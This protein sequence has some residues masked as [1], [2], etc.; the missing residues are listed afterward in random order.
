[1]NK[2]L[3]TILKLIKKNDSYKSLLSQISTENEV[4]LKNSAGSLI[5]L[6]ILSISEDLAGNTIFISNNISRLD[7]VFHD[8][9]LYG[10]TGNLNLIKEPQA[11]LRS[12]VS[13]TGSML[14]SLI[15]GL[16]SFSRNDSNILICQPEMFYH[17]IPSNQKIEGHY[18][19]I[20]KGDNTDYDSFIKS[21]VL[22]G[23]ERMD[24]ISGQG[25]IAVRGGIIDLYPIGWTNPLRIEFWGNDIDSIREFEVLSQRSIRE[26]DS[27]EF[28][29]SM[30]I[31][32]DSLEDDKTA[33]DY[34]DSDTI[35]FFD[36]NV[37][38]SEILENISG[39]N[40][41]SLILNPVGSSKSGIN[42]VN[43]PSFNG[44]VK[45]L[46]NEINRLSL[47]NFKIFLSCEGK[48]HLD[49]FK[50][51]IKSTVA[52]I[53][54]S[55][56][57]TNF[58]LNDEILDKVVNWDSESLS[59]GFISDELKAAYFTEH[60]VFERHRIYDS[61]RSGKSK[62]LTL[63]ELQELR[64][65]DYV[66]HEDKGIGI[67]DGF[68][69]IKIGD[70]MQDCARVRFADG[71]MLYVHLNYI[72]KLSKYSAQDGAAPILSKL[73]STDW[74]RRKAR[75][76][77]RLKD[78]ARDLIKLYAERKAQKGYAF[79]PDTT[80]Q[81]EFE[82]SFIYEDTPD[83]ATATEDVKSDMESTSPM[84][85][86]ICGDVGFGK[87]E[88]AI[89]AAF[90]AVQSGKQAA[91]LVPTTILAQQHF[92]SFKDRLS[93]YPVNVDV[94]SR[95]RKRKDQ[96]EITEKIKQG[97]I[98]ILI[99]THRILSKDI[100]FKNLGLLVVDE[101]HRFGVGH[102]EKL[103][104]LRANV[105]TLT[106]TA[107]PIP[108]TLNFSLMGARDLSLIETPP[109]NRIPVITEIIEWD[110]DII[111]QAINTEIERGGQV[112][113]V[114]DK[115]EDIQKIATDIKA[116][117]P[118]L[119]IAVGHGQMKPSDLEEI[120]EEF[121]EG[122][123]DI[124]VATKIIESGID[125]P[126]ANTMIINRAQNF[127]LAELYQLRGRVGRSNV[128][129]YC[130]LLAPP[131]HKLQQKSIQRLQAIEEF[132]ELGSGFKLSMRDL[133]IRG[134]GN[135]LGAEQSGFIIDIGFEL[136]QKV[137][138]EAVNELK[139]SEFS[140][141]F[142]ES[143]IDDKPKYLNEEI[144]IETDEDAL[145]PPDYIKGDTDRFMYYKKLYSLKNTSEL[146]DIVNEIED[147]FGKMPK[148][149]KN[150]VFAVR[151]RIAALTTG[152]TRLIIK[153]NKLVCEFPPSDFKEYYDEVFPHIVDYLNQ[154]EGVSL[155]QAKEKVFLE[156]PLRKRDETLE[157]IWKIKKIT[158]LSYT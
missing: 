93:K 45:I 39:K 35:L 3:G 4:H 24:Y 15:E 143:P 151:L 139:V 80:W 36:D 132:T 110:K 122:K 155:R 142:G 21:L 152:F 41:K 101:E 119:N 137:L 88:V 56:D 10:F 108:R 70:S 42:S 63:K 112:F 16:I 72:G 87:T 111:I 149:A 107:T 50:Q 6:L 27:V 126:N 130:Y 67:F 109:R 135:L 48:I 91:V 14:D 66:V 78:I 106:L 104:Q 124:L 156:I 116:Y 47:E 131:A 81:S 38:P 117:L 59:K 29:D 23:F 103:R 123:Y 113:F 157:Y 86:L 84:D 154:T 51:L 74:L 26:F 98:D 121:I 30:F 127:G 85:R 5:S 53:S 145:F 83:Q 68:Q 138:D 75:T 120:M 76:K 8:I 65:G 97:K 52:D 147:K 32:S 33:Y 99:G 61:K 140:D 134:A 129:A 20:S 92:M 31:D 22:N 7:D 141:I 57:N 54:E 94:I 40:V 1:M 69:T 46:A 55:E 153:H 73:G 136:Y 89:R 144:A 96:I 125:I 11:S 43:Q 71:D 150:L 82:A 64:I 148:P 37:N 118:H 19:K 133:E 17:K 62:S 77:K 102:K 60:E 9:K 95:F 58:V 146:E 49:R 105:D 114:S 25:Q 128:Q 115:I 13:N 12:K 44:A 90:K 34:I 158:E 2:N 18:R 100:E 28:L 79:P